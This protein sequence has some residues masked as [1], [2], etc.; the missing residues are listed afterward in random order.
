[1]RNYFIGARGGLVLDVKAR[2]PNIDSERRFTRAVDSPQSLLYAHLFKILAILT[3]KV[4]TCR[5][6]LIS[7]CPTVFYPCT[8]VLAAALLLFSCA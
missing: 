3:A 5:V 1:M 8:P 7:I 2:D 4:S 6:S